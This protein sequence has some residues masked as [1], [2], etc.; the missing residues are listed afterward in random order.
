MLKNW[1]YNEEYLDNVLIMIS[2]SCYFHHDITH[3]VKMKIFYT[4]TIMI[5]QITQ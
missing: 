1:S 2:R 4:T 3:N 5:T